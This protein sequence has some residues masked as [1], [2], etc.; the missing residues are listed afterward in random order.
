[1]LKRNIN[2]LARDNSRTPVQW[3]ASENGGFSTGKPWMRVNDSYKYINA[4]SQVD[5]T[6]SLYNY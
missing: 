3:N 2:L 6:D 4:A 5:D 1:M